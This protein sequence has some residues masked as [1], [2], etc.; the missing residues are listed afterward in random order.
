[1]SDTALVPMMEDASAL[2]IQRE[3]EQVLEEAHRAAKALKDVIDAKP[4]KIMFGPQG[5][6]KQYLTFEDWQTVGRFYGIA[7]RIVSS[8]PLTLEGGATGW[9]ALAEAVHVPTGRVVSSADAMCMDDEEKW[10]AR[11]KYAYV[12]HKRS[13]GTSVEDPGK[14]ELIWE[15]GAD[16][17]SRPKKERMQVG[18]E[19]VPQFQLRSMA[20]TRAGAKALRNALAWVVVLAGYAPTPAEE[21]PDAE[22]QRPVAEDA[23]ITRTETS[24]GRP[25]T[26]SAETTPAP[27]APESTGGAQETIE[28]EAERRFPDDPPPVV[29]PNGTPVESIDRAYLI[30]QIKGAADKAK[31]TAFEKGEYQRKYLGGA[32]VEKADVAALSDLLKAIRERQPA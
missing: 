22:P 30:G 24:A 19:N 32:S 23:A 31:M 4:D 26:L 14:D 7:P 29:Q 18:M 6:Q 3:P 1:M 15:K 27:A 20:Q 2:A 16:G 10:S 12:Y 8:K 5:K 13:G 21:M 28:E 9:E 25:G 17:K 11:P